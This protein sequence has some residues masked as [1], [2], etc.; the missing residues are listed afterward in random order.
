M[1]KALLVMDMQ[2]FCVGKNSC[3]IFKYNNSELIKNV[4]SIIS[5]SLQYSV[6]ATVTS[7]KNC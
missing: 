6:E 2:N 1:N 7:L 4:N 5:I 3:D